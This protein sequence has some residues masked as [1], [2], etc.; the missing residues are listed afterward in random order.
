MKEK[1]LLQGKEHPQ[2][3]EHLKEQAQPEHLRS[4]HMGESYR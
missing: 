1:V 4:H 3:T 2:V